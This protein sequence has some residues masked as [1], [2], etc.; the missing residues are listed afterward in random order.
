MT[1]MVLLSAW[2]ASQVEFW[3]PIKGRLGYDVSSFGRL[4]SWWTQRN[5]KQPTHGA[6]LQTFLTNTP[7]ILNPSPGGGGY[8][9]HV[10]NRSGKRVLVQ[11][12]VAETFLPNLTRAR[13]VNHLTGL[14]TDNRQGNLEWATHKENIAHALRVG[15]RRQTGEDNCRALVTETDVRTI[16]QRYANG[17]TQTSIALDYGVKNVTIQAITSRR[18]WKH[19]D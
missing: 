1:A 19:V 11:R 9:G 5:V 15:L 4:R 8:L 13:T 14:K 3:R 12:V 18:N 7:R 10:L 2:Q 16:R 17:E 6:K